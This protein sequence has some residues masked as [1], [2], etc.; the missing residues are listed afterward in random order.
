MTKLTR[1]TEYA[2]KLF[3]KYDTQTAKEIF[4]Q[5][6]G[7]VKTSTI[8]VADGGDKKIDSEEF[9][10]AL[11][12]FDSKINPNY[13]D[14]YEEWSQSYTLENPIT[15]SKSF[16]QALTDAFKMFHLVT[17]PLSNKK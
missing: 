10:N 17:V 13:K 11:K 5:E 2:D 3:N 14:L 7:T 16:L 9:R 6:R 8:K 12:I 1:Q 15:D 4:Y